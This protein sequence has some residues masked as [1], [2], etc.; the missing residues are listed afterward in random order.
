[1]KTPE[2]LRKQLL[3]KFFQ[4]SK[5]QILVKDD[6]GDEIISEDIWKGVAE[7]GNTSASVLERLANLVDFDSEINRRKKIAIAII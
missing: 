2:K 4:F 7:S 3:E 6:Y 1:M 5:N